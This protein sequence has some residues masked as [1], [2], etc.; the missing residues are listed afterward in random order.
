[1]RDSYMLQQYSKTV[2]WQHRRL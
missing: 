2:D 1:V